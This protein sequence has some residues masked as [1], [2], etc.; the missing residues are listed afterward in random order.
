MHIFM[1]GDR[2]KQYLQ[3]ELYYECYKVVIFNIEKE[4]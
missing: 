3:K 1:S 2:R 4:A